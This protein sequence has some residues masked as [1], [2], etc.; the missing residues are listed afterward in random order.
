[1]ALTPAERAKRYRNKIKQDPEKLKEHK[2]K[3]S[4]RMQSYNKKIK[5]LSEEQQEEQRRKWREQKKKQAQKRKAANNSN[6]NVDEASTSKTTVKG[7]TRRNTGSTLVL[8][9]NKLMTEHRRTLKAVEQYKRNYNRLR[10]SLFRQK[11]NSEN[12]IKQLQC[13]NEKLKVRQEI[14]EVTLKNVYQNADRLVE[15]QKIK[16]AMQKQPK[17]LC[18]KSE[19]KVLGLKYPLRMTQMKNRKC[20][21]NRDDIS[22]MTA[23]KR[24]T[25]TKAKKK[26]QIR[27]LVDTLQ[28]LH[29]VYKN[30]GGTISFSTFCRYKPYYVLS[31][32]VHRRET[33]LC[34]KHANM[35]FMFIALKHK[36]V[37]THKN[38]DELLVAASCDTKSYTCMYNKCEQCKNI[39]FQ[40]SENNQT[41]EI[42]WSKWVR[43][44]HNYQKA[45]KQLTTKKTVK[46]QIKGTIYEL[47]REIKKEMP[48]FK[49]H[50]FNWK[51]Q[52]RQYRT[53][54]NNLKD[55]EIAIIC[56]FSENYECKYGQEIQ[57]THFGASKNA[58]TL[59]TGMIFTKDSSQSFASLS[60]NTC[61]EPHAIWAHLMPIL[62]Y[63]KNMNQQRKTIHFFSD[64]PSSQYRQKKNFFLLSLFTAKLGLSYSTWS[65]SEAGHGKSIADGIGGSM[66]RALDKRVSYGVD[67]TNANDAY[68]ILQRSGTSVKCFFIP[69]EDIENFKKLVPIN[70]EVLPG[71]MQLHQITTSQ[72]N[73]IQYRQLSCFCG[74][75]RGFCNCYNPKTHVFLRGCLDIPAAPAV[76]EIASITADTSEV[77][78]IPIVS[79]VDT[80]PNEPNLLQSLNFDHVMDDF[81]QDFV[82]LNCEEPQFY[83][84]SH[85]DNYNLNCDLD[86]SASYN[87]HSFSLNDHILNTPENT[88]SSL[89][90]NQDITDIPLDY[91]LPAS[92]ILSPVNNQDNSNDKVR[93]LKSIN[94]HDEMAYRPLAKR[95]RVLLPKKVEPK[96]YHIIPSSKE[97]KVRKISSRTFLCFTCKKRK[98]FN[99]EEMAKCMVCSNWVCLSCSNTILDYVCAMCLSQ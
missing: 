64:G 52:Q 67:I 21:F 5:E 88:K 23:G 19:A 16:E 36:G 57:S 48:L 22:R 65:F 42:K 73:Q 37:I 90:Q 40:H 46:T 34:I 45:G 98:E 25:R 76:T 33:C 81:Q 13:E 95:P 30:E 44:S 94:I 70:L 56:D 68:N 82:S 55:D 74:E 59:H 84:A 99:L 49:T 1:M 93:I 54:V 28:N 62:R 96:H 63:S 10:K 27:Y 72:E 17:K 3:K 80:D 8:R 2:E 75:I 7:N 11:L 87:P 24:E 91:E 66:K 69:E 32:S 4:K 38:L 31:P 83:N 26:S 39:S 47:L 6:Q 77:A 58:V 86:F 43:V 53:C 15:K 97:N 29:E 20:F 85:N 60:D 79:E 50:H 89:L 61:H 51:E 14:M 18:K 41:D 35:E 71:T 92:Q 12:R 9:Y 78:D